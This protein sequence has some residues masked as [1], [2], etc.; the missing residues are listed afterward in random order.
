LVDGSNLEVVLSEFVT[1]GN[2]KLAIDSS[3]PLYYQLYL[4]LQRYIQ[5]QGLRAGDRFPSEEIIAVSFDISRPT[6]NKAVQELV[7]EGWLVRKRGRGTFVQRKPPAHLA[8]L[9]SSLSFMEQFP[10]D[11]PHR[12]ELVRKAVV[13]SSPQEAELLRL[14]IEE[15]LVYIRQVRFVRERP[16]M[17]CD[18]KLPSNRF[19]HLEEHLF[20]D[21]S[22]YATLEREYGVSIS[23]SER[24]V[25][26][27]YVRDEEAADLL[28][29]PMLSPILLLTELTVTVEKE[30][31]EYVTSY[32][33]EGVACK[34][35]VYHHPGIDR[36]RFPS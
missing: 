18:A 23:Q 17:V 31:I 34:C 27:A 29:I 36:R 2:G 30:P 19:P 33:K 4:I 6:A 35:I 11:L 12:T 21:T 24:R 13:P 10:P 26:A 15:P 25:E 28:G 9:S 1:S 7:N 22:L 16:V 20:G 3:I 5:E 8:L 32:I 14:K